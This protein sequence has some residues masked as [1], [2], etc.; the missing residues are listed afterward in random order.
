MK[1]EVGLAV[2]TKV[3]TPIHAPAAVLELHAT[4]HRPQ[5]GAGQCKSAFHPTLG[6]L[7][8]E[9]AGYFAG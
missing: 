6:T 1:R 5:Q 4:V 8:L 7:F 3:K 2:V 9:R